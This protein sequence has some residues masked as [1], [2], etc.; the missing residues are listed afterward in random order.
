MRTAV[1][2]EESIKHFVRM[3]YRPMLFCKLHFP[4]KLAT[5]KDMK[6]C[7]ILSIFFTS[8]QDVTLDTESF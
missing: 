1:S 5:A 2:Q 3:K 6:F 7:L 4:D 8:W